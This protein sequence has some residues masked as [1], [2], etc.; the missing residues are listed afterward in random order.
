MAVSKKFRSDNLTSSIEAQLTVPQSYIQ[1]ESFLDKE[2]ERQIRIEEL[3]TI[4]EYNKSLS[5]NNGERKKYAHKIFLLTGIWSIMI[6]FMLFLMGFKKLDLSDKVIIA[7]I[8]STTINFFGFF[9]LVTRYLFNAGMPEVTSKSL[10]P[11]PLRKRGAKNF[12]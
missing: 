4:K 7:L 11:T 8:S 9:Y 10:T 3:N 2:V 1:E 12:T 6:F 5:Q